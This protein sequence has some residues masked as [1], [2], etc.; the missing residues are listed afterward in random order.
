MNSLV[1]YTS[2][3][4]NTKAVAEYIAKKTDGIA[5]EAG[6]VADKDLK[7]YDAI[8]L[9]SQIHAGKI[10]K[11][12][13]EFICKNSYIDISREEAVDGQLIGR[14]IDHSQ[15]LDGQILTFWPPLALVLA[16]AHNQAAA[17]L[18]GLH[19]AAHILVRTQARRAVVATATMLALEVIDRLARMFL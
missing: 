14:R 5:V 16:E 17:P 13:Q 6:N 9:G 7:S 4:G 1:V 12:L 18:V 15:L 8:V 19:H 3:T 2:T 10:S 11:G